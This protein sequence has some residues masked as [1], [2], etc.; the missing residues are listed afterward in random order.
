VLWQLKLGLK[1]VFGPLGNV[2]VLVGALD[3]LVTD[4]EVLEEALE[5][6]LEVGGAIEVEEV[7]VAIQLH[8]LLTRLATLPV[9]AATANEGIAPVAVT[10][11][12][13]KVPQNASAASRRSDA[14]RARRQ[15]S[16]LQLA[17]TSTAIK[18]TGRK[19]E[20]RGG[21]LEMEAADFGLAGRCTVTRY[22]GYTL[23]TPFFGHG[24]YL[25]ATRGPSLQEQS[26]PRTNE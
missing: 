6:A 10:G 2:G 26:L 4:T 16:E 23:Y 3:V 5:V 9:H 11:A 13:V 14:R 1:Q 7:T 15:L 19:R 20:A 24:P 18:S 8:A 25:W 17:A 22:R 12:V 21:I